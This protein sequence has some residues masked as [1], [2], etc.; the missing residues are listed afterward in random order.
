MSFKENLLKFIQENLVGKDSQTKIGEDDNLI[1]EGLLD[2]MGLLKLVTFI[3]E[4][5]GVRISDDN[6]LLEN[7]E[8]VSQIH[9]FVEQLQQQNS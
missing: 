2:S 5:L 9:R 3:E 8:T 1:N 6:I 4:N 7:F